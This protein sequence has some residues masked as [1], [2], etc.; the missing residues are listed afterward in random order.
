MARIGPNAVIRVAEA[1]DAVEGRPVA[2]RLFQAVGIR[3]YLDAPPRDMV[4]E[5]E[6]RSLHEELHR[7]LGDRR[8]RSIGWIAGQRTADYL[9]AHRI[10]AAVQRL[11]HWL[12]RR[13]AARV[14]SR[15]IAGHAWTFTGSG[16]LRVEPGNPTAFRIAHCPLCRGLHGAEPACDYYVA[17]FERLFA[18]LIHA[19]ARATETACMARGDAECRISIGWP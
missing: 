19:D 14:L 17:T 11:L 7:A 10:P 9:L 8:A 4:A 12:P 16:R 1:L 13:T 6:V 18:V 3:R 15:A 2:E 5:D